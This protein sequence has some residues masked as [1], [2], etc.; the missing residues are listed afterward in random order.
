MMRIKLILYCVFYLY[1][2]RSLKRL[3]KISVREVS[4]LSNTVNEFFILKTFKL[5]MQNKLSR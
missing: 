1:T 3:Q 2:Y 5:L 4:I